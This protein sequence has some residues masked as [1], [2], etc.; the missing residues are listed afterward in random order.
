MHVTA[1]LAPAHDA[2]ALDDARRAVFL[3]KADVAIDDASLASLR[4]R[5]DAELGID[6][7][8]LAAA[9]DAFALDP[10]ATMARA[11]TQGT[12][13]RLYAVSF[14]G[15]PLRYLRIAVFPGEYEAACMAL[16]CRLMEALRSLP[17]PVP[18]C[19]FSLLEREAEVR[20][21]H[22]VDR[23]AGTAVSAL[24]GD[25][26]RMGTALAAAARLLAALHALQGSGFGPLS[27]AWPGGS[28]Q[29]G[30]SARLAGVHRRWNGFLRTRLDE[31]L[32]ESL[33]GGAIDDAEAR[34]ID[35][36]LDA[37]CVHGA[38]EGGALLHGD[39]G[40][41]NF[42]VG[43]EGV[44]AVLDWEDALLGDPLFDVASLCAFHPERRHAVILDAYAF[45][46][47]DRDAVARFW[48]YFL[49]IAVARTV[50][51]FRFAY[52]DPPDRPRA[53][54]RIQLA[55]ARLAALN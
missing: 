51:R 2:D 44:S 25:E 20:G 31:H 55:L 1:A 8:L 39:P 3:S 49:R 10:A 16:E 28:L 41:P 38:M 12:F 50:H 24:E 15:G 5:P 54:G 4:E 21:A 17:M 11:P 30:G 19:A 47:G 13:H 29:A 22:L 40:S 46:R 18:R 9:R 6:G 27:L 34:S 43:A 42:I 37:P 35:A 26:A 14:P 36:W 32:A 52:P 23:A 45:P 53:S 7:K 48:I 33:E